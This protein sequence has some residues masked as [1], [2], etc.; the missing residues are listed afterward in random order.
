MN[1]QLIS[2]S[3]CDMTQAEAK[4]LPACPEGKE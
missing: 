3:A 1:V 4:E 2:D